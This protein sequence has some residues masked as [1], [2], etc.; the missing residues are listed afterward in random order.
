V[1]RAGCGPWSYEVQA[2]TSSAP[3]DPPSNVKLATI[4]SNQVLVEWDPPPSNGEEICFY[5]VE[6]RQGEE[7]R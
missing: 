3:P 4:C 1:N 2:K 6:M 5:T 7:K